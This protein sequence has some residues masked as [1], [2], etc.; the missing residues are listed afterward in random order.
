MT[1]EDFEK[2]QSP[3]GSPASG[4]PESDPAQEQQRSEPMPAPQ[5]QQRSVDMSPSLPHEH[6]PAE[7]CADD[8]SLSPTTAA[9]AQPEA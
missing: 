3:G 2:Y 1:Y 9:A 6:D 5:E 4:Q 8:A 7:M